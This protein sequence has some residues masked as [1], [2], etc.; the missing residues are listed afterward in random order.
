MNYRALFKPCLIKY[1][2]SDIFLFCYIF[3]AIELN[4]CLL[5]VIVGKHLNDGSFLQQLCL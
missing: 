3:F 1:K 4:S 5:D 2:L